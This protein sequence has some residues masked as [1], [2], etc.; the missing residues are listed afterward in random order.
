MGG[1]LTKTGGGQAMPGFF[2]ML[3]LPRVYVGALFCLVA[4]VLLKRGWL[5]HN[6][7][8]VALP[9]I[10]FVFAMLWM[11]P[12]GR[13]AMG[14]GPHPS[15]LCT[16]TKPFLFVKDGYS[17]PVIFFAIFVSMAV[18][19]VIG[20][21]FFCGWVCPIG[22]I[23]ELSHRV[24]LPSSFKKKLPFKVTN[25]IR[26]VL[27]AV[28]VPTVALAGVSIYDY[29][30]PFE[31]LHWHFTLNLTVTFSVI[32]LAALFV[33]RPFCYLVCPLGLITWALEHIAIFKV[34]VDTEACTE[35]DICV[36]E[37]PCPSVRAILDRKISKPDCH[38]CGR[39]IETC[40]EGALK[41]R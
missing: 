17:V 8:L 25:T 31:L 5:S 35:C 1:L 10:F 26:V 38:A 27:F 39:C 37:S 23:Q 22:A 3:L 29:F 2:E 36:D 14:M 11:L 34:K 7:R 21:K 16:V 30:N 24:P 9:V 13:F 20:N 32:L 19:S 6:L 4:L 40:P 12:L 33:F 28:F 41:F 18:V 15:P